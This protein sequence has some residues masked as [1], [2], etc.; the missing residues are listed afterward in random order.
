MPLPSSGS[1]SASQINVELNRSATA[2]LS[3]NDSAVRQLAGLLDGAVTFSGLRGKAAGVLMG[4]IGNGYD[5]ATYTAI[6]AQYQYLFDSHSVATRRGAITFAGGYKIFGGHPSR[7]HS[8]FNV[9]AFG[10]DDTGNGA[11]LHVINFIGGLAPTSIGV[12][13]R[14]SLTTG[15]Y[16][17]LDANY[18]GVAPFQTGIK[19]TYANYAQAN[20]NWSPVIEGYQLLDGAGVY[21][22]SSSGYAVSGSRAYVY[23]Q[24]NLFSYS[25]VSRLFY[26]ETSNYTRVIY[27]ATTNDGTNAWIGTQTQDKT[28][29]VVYDGENN[30]RIRGDGVIFS[31][32]SFYTHNNFQLTHFLYVPLTTALVRNNTLTYYEVVAFDF[33]GSTTNCARF[34]NSNETTAAGTAS[35]LQVR[36]TGSGYDHYFYGGTSSVEGG[37]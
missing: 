22:G 25:P 17:G 9:T 18:T 36:P 33:Y 8:S 7:I 27:G 30:I 37:A 23:P 31:S 2:T 28:I 19:I 5:A 20:I 29:Q 14:D 24:S 34:F 21:A 13:Q 35:G 32:G 6:G 16:V 4:I 10:Y 26:L 3:L 1:L 15:A 11:L 12:A